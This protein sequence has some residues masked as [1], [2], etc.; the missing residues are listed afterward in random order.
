MIRNQLEY[1]GLNVMRPEMKWESVPLPNPDVPVFHMEWDDEN[2]RES[3]FPFLGG[4]ESHG[5]RTLET[6]AEIA[7]PLMASLLRAGRRIPEDIA[8]ISF[9]RSAYSDMTPVPLTSL[10]HPKEEIGRVAAR[11]LL[12]MIQGKKEHSELLPWTLEER[13]STNIKLR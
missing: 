5:G 12:R 11:K 6:A 8:V 9:D 4:V 7:A 2:F 13:A 10:T 1:A 3:I